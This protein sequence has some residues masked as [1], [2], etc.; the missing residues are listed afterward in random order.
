MDDIIVRYPND[1]PDTV[2][3]ATILDDNGDYNVYLNPHFSIE[4]LSRVFRHELCHIKRG[5]FYDD[6]TPLSEKEAEADAAEE[7]DK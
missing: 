2:P 6:I 5:H 1:M 3:G 4:Y 7:K